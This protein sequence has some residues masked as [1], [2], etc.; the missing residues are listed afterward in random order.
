MTKLYLHYNKLQ[1]TKGISEDERCLII[2][3]WYDKTREAYAEQQF[4][5]EFTK[6]SVC[7]C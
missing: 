5:E 3:E 7:S 6:V 1:T 2:Q 4:S